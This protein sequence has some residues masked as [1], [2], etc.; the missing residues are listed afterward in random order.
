[1]RGAGALLG[2]EGLGAGGDTCDVGGGCNGLSADEEVTAVGA[3]SEI[4][5]A[6]ETFFVV[7]SGI[8]GICGNITTG[9]PCGLSSASIRDS[10]TI[11]S[12]IPAPV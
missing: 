10:D 11:I 1:M 7:D 5:V 12:G 3:V 4:R 9:P 2:E 6:F 8:V